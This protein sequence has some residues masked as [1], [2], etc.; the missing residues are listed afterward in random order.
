MNKY[1]L[2]VA[3]ILVSSFSDSSYGRESKND[4]NSNAGM[5]KYCLQVEE[6]G[7]KAVS[8][9]NK[10]LENPDEM[11]SDEPGLDQA[12]K[13][14]QADIEMADRISCSNAAEIKKTSNEGL[15]AVEQ[16][17]T[18]LSKQAKVEKAVP[19]QKPN[20]IYSDLRELKEL[21]DSGAITQEEFEKLKDRILAK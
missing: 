11:V 3:V 5:E 4:K 1:F 9:L 12:E 7:R 13:Y 20:S 19:A 15:L 8:T 17:R 10:E 6:L 14:F 16:L 18:E 2:F 21:L